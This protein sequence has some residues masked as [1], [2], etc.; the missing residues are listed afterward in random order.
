MQYNEMIETC[1]LQV[2][3]LVNR[4]I[5]D[6]IEEDIKRQV[7]VKVKET[8]WSLVDG[9]VYNEVVLPVKYIVRENFIH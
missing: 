2:R 7:S 4:K 8:V 6:R 1:R 3:F 9:R 5:I